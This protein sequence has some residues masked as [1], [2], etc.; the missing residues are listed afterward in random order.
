M[1]QFFYNIATLRENARCKNKL[2]S[3]ALILKSIRSYHSKDWTKPKGLRF[4]CYKR[5]F[6]A[7]FLRKE[8]FNKHFQDGLRFKTTQSVEQEICKQN[9]NGS[10]L[11]TYTKLNGTENIYFSFGD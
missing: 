6:Q 10:Q 7:A 4:S 5:S 1:N 11:Q 9:K 8:H 3:L 2:R